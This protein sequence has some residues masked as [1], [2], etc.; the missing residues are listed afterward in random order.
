MTDVVAALRVEQLRRLEAASGRFGAA[1]SRVDADWLT[2]PDAQ[3]GERWDRGQLASH[4]AEMVEYWV[5]QVQ[6][7]GS[8]GAGVDFGRT[9]ATPS[10]L[11]RIEEGRRVELSD[12]LARID[13]GV[14]AARELIEGLSGAQLGYVGHH[15]TLGDMDVARIVEEFLVGHL[16]EHVD[17]LEHSHAEEADT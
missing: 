12:Q 14:A 5:E 16:E 2:A 4:V 8:V 1:A 7:V 9:K 15:P 11:A 17:Q 10:R 13:R 6:L 3:T